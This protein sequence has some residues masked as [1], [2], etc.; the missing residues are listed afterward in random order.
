MESKRLRRARWIALGLITGLIA[1]WGGFGLV[2]AAPSSIT[3]CTKVSTQ[4]T[5]VIGSDAASVATC[6]N[7]GKGVRRTWDD[8]TIVAVKDTSLAAAKQDACNLYDEGLN[9]VPLQ[10][11]ASSNIAFAQ[12]MQNAFSRCVDPSAAPS[13][14]TTC[15]KTSTQKMKIIG[16]DAGSKAKCTNKGKG[17][18]TTWD[19][20]ATLATKVASLAAA[21]QEACDLNNEMASPNLQTEY[22]NNPAFQATVINANNRCYALI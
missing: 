1:A 17:T 3:T 20:H 9:S 6:T 15:T 18:T 10:N 19:D 7:K 4:K 16:S 11:E 12:T 14:I 13:R 22:F 2:G 8:H 5:K 21:K